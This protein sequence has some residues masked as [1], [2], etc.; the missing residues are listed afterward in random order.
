MSIHCFERKDDPPPPP[1]MDRPALLAKIKLF[2]QRG[3]S[4]TEAADLLCQTIRHG[5]VKD[6]AQ[7]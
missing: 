7:S 4:A 3:G 6:R 1:K 2:L 5:D